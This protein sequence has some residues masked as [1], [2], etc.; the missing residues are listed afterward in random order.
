MSRNSRAEEILAR[1]S[2]E[3]LSSN[4][5]IYRT[6][7]RTMMTPTLP[8]SPYKSRPNTVSRSTPRHWAYR[9]EKLRLSSNSR[10]SRK[11]KDLLS[12]SS[13]GGSNLNKVS[14]EDTH[15]TYSKTFSPTRLSV[16]ESAV[17]TSEFKLL[18]HFAPSELNNL[19]EVTKFGEALQVFSCTDDLEINY[20][21]ARGQAEVPTAS[22]THIGTFLNLSES[23]EEVTILSYD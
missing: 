22:K 15:D 14:T 19:S 11:H 6:Y 8:L 4:L 13:R 21:I 7:C 16:P 20:S 2:R 5:D 9:E 12:D 3:G 17:P 1:L 10:F 23:L 18:R